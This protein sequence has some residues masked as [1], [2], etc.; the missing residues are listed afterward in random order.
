MAVSKK[1][2]RTGGRPN[3]FASGRMVPL[4]LRVPKDLLEKLVRHLGSTGQD[5][6]A[7]VR[8]AIAEKIGASMKPAKK[9]ERTCSECGCTE[10]RACDAGFGDGCHWV[11][12]NLCSVCAGAV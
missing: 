1:P 3:K 6:S 4:N 2:V 5:L 7:V 10:D 9:P 12:P 11:G 8:D